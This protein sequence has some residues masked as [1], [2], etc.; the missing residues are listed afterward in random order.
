MLFMNVFC[1]RHRLRNNV[2]VLS[3]N[4]WC[5]ARRGGR[6]RLLTY[7]LFQPFSVFSRTQVWKMENALACGLVRPRWDFFCP[8]RFPAP[9]F[10]NEHERKCLRGWFLLDVQLYYTAKNN[11]DTLKK[12]LS[13]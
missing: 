5:A 9:A 4:A 7:L 8:S 13:C 10:L 3:E 6:A 12:T 11:D 2:G 1:R